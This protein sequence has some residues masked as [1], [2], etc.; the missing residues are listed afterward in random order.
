MWPL[1]AE[2]APVWYP[3]VLLS[4]TA[5]ANQWSKLEERRKLSVILNVYYEKIVVFFY[6][7]EEILQ[8]KISNFS[9]KI[10]R[11]LVLQGYWLPKTETI[12]CIQL[13]W[14]ETQQ[15]QKHDPAKFPSFCSTRLSLGILCKEKKS[16][17]K[18]AL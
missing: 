13:Y 16:R 17:G 1:K 10:K 15:L 4:R 6:W 12:H 9:K 2:V 5:T 11:A 14:S 8:N 18:N 3:Q 7:M